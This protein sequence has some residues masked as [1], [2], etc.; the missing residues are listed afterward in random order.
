MLFA[1][2]LVAKPNTENVIENL[3][4]KHRAY[5]DAKLDDTYF[6]GPLYG[7]DSKNRIGGLMVIDFSNH[8]KAEQF[9]LNQPYYQAGIIEIMHI[10]PFKP[11]IERGKMLVESGF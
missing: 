1:I 6:G 4:T 2:Y 7:Q 9:M 11:L 10:Y 8:H 5:Y 3:L